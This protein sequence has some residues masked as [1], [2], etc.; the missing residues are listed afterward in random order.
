MNDNSWCEIFADFSKTA[1]KNEKMKH[2]FEDSINMNILNGKLYR[3]NNSIM[4]A[5]VLSKI[6]SFLPLKFEYVNFIFLI[7]SISFTFY[8]PEEYWF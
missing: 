5:E 8:V 7:S 1:E 4:K 6:T 3:K 2:C